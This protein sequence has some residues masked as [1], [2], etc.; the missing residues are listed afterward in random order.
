M[1]TIYLI[2]T[3]TQ[4]KELKNEIM[5]TLVDVIENDRYILGK[6]LEK[7]ENDFARFN[8]VKHAIG[9]ASGTDALFL[10]LKC[11]GIGSGDEVI[12]TPLTHI[13]TVFSI[14]QAGAKPIFVDVDPDT[15]LL[16]TKVIENYITKKTKAIIPVHL[17]GFPVNMPTLMQF[18]KKYNLLIVE[19]ACQAHGARIAGRNV[20]AWGD[21]GV[22]SFYPTKNLAAIGD[23]GMI[24]TDNTEI[25][26]MLQ[27]IR[28]FGQTDPYY[29]PKFGYNSRLDTIQAAVLKIGLN[30]LEKRNKKRRTIASIYNKLLSAFPV[31]LPH[32]GSE[33]GYYPVFNLYPILIT[34]RDGLAKYLWK[35]GVQTGKHYPIP[36]H[37]QPSLKELGYKKGEF[38]KAEKISSQVLTLPIHP[39]L[40]DSDISYITAKI[41]S[42]FKTK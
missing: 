34:K 15:F 28:N 29:H 4:F 32:L 14:L 8:N 35:H 39:Q 41:S 40:N 20:G 26:K 23:G 5:K 7:F 24:I 1:R 38:P 6:A 31:K 19:D 11:L 37:L 10:S 2:D 42:W 22:F 25:S 18:A 17:Y 36:L 33:E 30:Y 3:K 27:I 13:S 21:V 12:T 9:V 16:D